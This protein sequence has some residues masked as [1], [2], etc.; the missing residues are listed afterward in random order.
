MVILGDEVLGPFASQQRLECLGRKRG[1]GGA[2][3]SWGLSQMCVGEPPYGGSEREGSSRGVVG[4][5][6]R[7]NA[8]PD[9]MYNR[10]GR[11]TR[12]AN[13]WGLYTMMLSAS[14]LCYGVAWDASARARAGLGRRVSAGA[15]PAL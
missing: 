14:G 11:V 1:S 4:W 3:E 2:H 5:A 8:A 15:E 13:L 10:S 12:P 9:R 7:P 6:G